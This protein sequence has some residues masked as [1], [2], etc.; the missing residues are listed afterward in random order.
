MIN[1]EKTISLHHQWQGHAVLGSM[2]TH[3]CGDG[4]VR[5]HLGTLDVAT[6]LSMETPGRRHGEG[7]G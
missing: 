1:P 4:V 5:S 7:L 6:S 2:R 3:L